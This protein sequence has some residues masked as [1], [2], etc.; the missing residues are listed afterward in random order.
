MSVQR[1]SWTIA[2]IV[3][4]LSEDLAVPEDWVDLIS[5]LNPLTACVVWEVL[6]GKLTPAAVGLAQASPDLERYKVIDLI[7]KSDPQHINAVLEE[8]RQ[9]VD[10]I[11]IQVLPGDPRRIVH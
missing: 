5:R 3:Y 1:L 8:A 7:S 9:L 2:E 10:E 11:F 4:D 6:T